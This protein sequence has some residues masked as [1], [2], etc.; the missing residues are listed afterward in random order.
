MHSPWAPGTSRTAAM[1]V[2]QSTAPRGAGQKEFSAYV[3]RDR[4]GVCLGGTG[5]N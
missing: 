5:M 2:G 4:P 1:C 3:D